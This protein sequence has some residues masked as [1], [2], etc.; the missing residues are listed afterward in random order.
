M[1]LKAGAG[2]D[3]SHHKEAQILRLGDIGQVIFPQRIKLRD[4]VKGRAVVDHHEKASVLR[5]LFKPLDVGAYPREEAQDVASL[6]DKE[7]A[8]GVLLFSRP[9]RADEER[10]DQREEQKQ[11]AQA[12]HAA[13]KDQRAFPKAGGTDRGGKAVAHRAGKRQDQNDSHQH[14][15]MTLRKK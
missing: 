7:A 3:A 9:L 10:D 15:D 8:D 11:R 4:R 6:G 1:D 13:R 5:Q 12:Q 2:H 14:S